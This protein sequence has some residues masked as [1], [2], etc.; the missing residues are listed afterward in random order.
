MRP[1]I[2]GNYTLPP[3]EK[4]VTSSSVGGLSLTPSIMMGAALALGG[5]VAVAYYGLTR[6]RYENGE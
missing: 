6:R 5:G 3:V 1:Y 4:R 2:M